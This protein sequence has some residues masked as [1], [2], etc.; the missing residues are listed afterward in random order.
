MIDDAF[1]E[2]QV[3][4]L[5]PSRTP[6]KTLRPLRNELLA[7]SIVLQSQF[8]VLEDLEDQLPWHYSTGDYRSRPHKMALALQDTA[9]DRL[10]ILARLDALC[11][12]LRTEV[13]S[14][15]PVNLLSTTSP[16]A[17]WSIVRSSK[18]RYR[19]LAQ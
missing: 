11:T 4:G 15:A 8:D 2:E 18:R 14:K 7:A 13:G 10:D 12:D 19:R 17:D 1:Q 6:L 16:T 9:Q 3:W 5:E